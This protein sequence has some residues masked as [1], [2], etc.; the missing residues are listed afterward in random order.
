MHP[1]IVDL[2]IINLQNAGRPFK[3]KVS[4]IRM[5]IARALE[6][7]NEYIRVGF[8]E[9][10]IGLLKRRMEKMEI[11]KEAQHLKAAEARS[12]CKECEEYDHVQGKPRYNESLSIQDLVPLCAQF[13]NFMDEQAKINKDV[14]IKFEAMEI[15]TK[16]LDGKA[17]KVGS[18]IC[19]VFIKMKMLKMQVGQLVG[20]PM[21]DKE[22][23]PRQPQGPKTA[24]A[25][26]T[27]S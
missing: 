3:V 9:W 24:K 27:R 14:V 19:E 15:I 8:L 26:K 22:E 25:T 20:Q 16:T 18:S 17:T 13:K 10:H 7:F 2:P 23:F 21:G 12:T 1:G 6:R 4:T 11:E 5:T